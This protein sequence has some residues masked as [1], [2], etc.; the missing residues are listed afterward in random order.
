MFRGEE[1]NLNVGW[2]INSY[3]IFLLRPH[4]LSLC[5]AENTTNS[6]VQIKI[7]GKH[8]FIE[9]AADCK[10]W[11]EIQ[12]NCLQR[13]SLNSGYFSLRPTET[14]SNDEINFSALTKKTEK[15]LNF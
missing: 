9:S 5:S 12:K 6:K 1:I 11:N 7:Y 13:V 10:V 14:R 8:M 4:N 2:R 15:C 3:V